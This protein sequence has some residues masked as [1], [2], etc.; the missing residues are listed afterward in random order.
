MRKSS[1][2]DAILSYLQQHPDGATV[3]DIRAAVSARLGNIP[4]SSVRSSL[5]LNVSTV[6]DRLTTGRYRLKKHVSV[7]LPRQ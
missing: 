2:R 4:A 5:N 1:I 7:S 6:F 3:A